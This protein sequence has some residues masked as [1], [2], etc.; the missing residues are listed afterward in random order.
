M[1][2]IK[3]YEDVKSESDL[4]FILCNFLEKIDKS[5]FKVNHVIYEKGKNY[6]RSLSFE[7]IKQG[8]NTSFWGE[9]L[10]RAF[11]LRITPV[12]DKKLRSESIK[13]KI[14]ILLDSIY[15]TDDDTALTLIDFMTEIFKKYSYFNKKLVSFNNNKNGKYEF[16]INTSDIENIENDLKDFEF[17]ISSNKYNL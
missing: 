17:F 7:I 12:N 14:K 10:T 13:P 6:G 16:Y 9:K 2:Y 1:K 8:R 4:H 15:Y 5:K 3:T 11:T